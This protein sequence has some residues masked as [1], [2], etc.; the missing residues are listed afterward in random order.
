VGRN[1]TH[2]V[3]NWSFMYRLPFICKLNTRDREQYSLSA[4]KYKR[5]E[6]CRT[7]RK[8]LCSFSELPTFIR[9]MCLPQTKKLYI[10][11]LNGKAISAQNW[12]THTCGKT[13]PPC[14]PFELLSFCRKLF[15]CS[16]NV[17]VCVYKQLKLCTAVRQYHLKMII[18][19]LLLE[20]RV[21][22]EI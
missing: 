1:E 21:T 15:V 2:L 22:Y 12:K 11:T 17:T 3:S 16:E 8:E 6:D 9:V 14:F 18:I 13:A 19:I 4:E 7:Q 10:I 5:P 20:R